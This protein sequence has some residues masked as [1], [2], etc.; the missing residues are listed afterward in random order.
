MKKGQ[1]KLLLFEIFLIVFFLVSGFISS[2][3]NGY[4]LVT[5]LL[6][7]AIIFKFLFGF[8]KDNHRYTKEVIIQIIVILAISFSAYYLAGFIFGFAKTVNYYSFYGLT[9]FILPS[10]LT[11]ILE[12]YLRY[13]MLRKSEGSKLLI[14]LCCIFFIVI[15]VL[16]NMVMSVFS[17]YH[18]LFM[19]VA[20][21][22][23]PAISR[24]IACT[25]ISSKAGFKPNMIWVCVLRLYFYLIP[26]IPDVG[27]YIVAVIDLVFP[28]IILYFIYRYYQ[29]REDEDIPPRLLKKKDFISLPVTIFIVVAMV[30]LTSGFFRYQ[31][32]AI[33]SGSM[34][35]TINKG[36][37][38][39]IKRID[40]TSNLKKGDVVAFKYDGVLIVHR[41]INIVDTGDQILFYTKGDANSKPDNFYLE[42]SNIIGTV[43]VKI[44]YI[45]I[46]VVWLSEAAK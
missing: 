25:Y 26:L 12:E 44:P 28:L 21:N 7:L 37:A 39:I 18:Y 32:V 30:Y 40:D 1:K 13:N 6:V 36:D 35:G 42:D 17:T 16:N 38:V 27:N 34:T 11:I 14:V 19:F 33:G 41:L 24:N 22:V 4:K 23:I 2:I 45:G 5:L 9:V 20:L 10:F 29:K 3:L 43:N 31:I 8:E 46:P 15:D